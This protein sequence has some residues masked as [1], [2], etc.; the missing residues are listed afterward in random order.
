MRFGRSEAQWGKT[1]AGAI[2]TGTHGGDFDRPPLADAVHAIYLVGKGTALG[3][4]GT[5]HWIEPKSRQITDPAR[6]RAAFPCIQ[7][8]NIHYDDEMLRAVLVA[9]GAKGVIMR[10]S[11]T[12]F[13]S[14]RCSNSID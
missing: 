8:A 9:M 14:P 7:P 4:G 11:S 3:T 12:S 5:H 1:I 2:S 6:I 10:S 13:L